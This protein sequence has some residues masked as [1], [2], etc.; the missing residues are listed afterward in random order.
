MTRANC[1][2][3]VLLPA[4]NEEL[5]I[6]G[7]IA[8]FHGAMPSAR[9]YVIDNN[10]S[11]ETAAIAQK[12]L[13]QIKTG[14][15]LHE[16]RHGKGNALRRAFLEID[17]DIF[18]I[19]DADLTYP[20]EKIHELVAPI[21]E[22]RADMVIGDR[23][24]GGGYGRENSRKFHNFGN[25]LV[26][27]LINMFFGANLSDIM[28]GYRAFNRP[29]A[30]SYPFLMEGFQI[31][32]DMT[33]FALRHR[34]RILEIPIRYRNRPEGSFSKLN[35]FSDGLRVLSA[36]F[37]LFRHGKPLVFFSFIAVCVACLGLLAGFPVVWEFV[38]T[39]FIRHVPLAILASALEIVAI[40][41]FGVGLTLDS[42]VRR[43][44][45]DTERIIQTYSAKPYRE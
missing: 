39:G 7:V 42:V 3:A 18:V 27:T 1:D 6:A 4:F 22:G 33:I 16:L 20:P 25:N 28:T 19:A 43:N 24:S 37:N 5:T 12:I 29:F 14:A 9:I 23:L 36:I 13:A 44:D 31:E 35:T 10:S 11:D 30:R 40:T 45:I 32:T 15:L 8:A 34:F 41:I 38:N 26:R 17:A 2:V 21:A